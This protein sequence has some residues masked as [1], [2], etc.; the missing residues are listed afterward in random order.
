MTLCKGLTEKRE[1]CGK[2]L[3]AKSP[4][5]YC[6]KHRY[7]LDMTD[8]E[9]KNI[10]DGD[11]KY[12]ACSKCKKWFE[13]NNKR[14]VKCTESDTNQNEKRK[15]T[16]GEYCEALIS[17][18]KTKQC[19]SHQISNSK[20][21][22]KHEYLKDFTDDML[23]SSKI[24]T[25]PTCHRTFCDSPE[26]GTCQK[27]RKTG[28]QNRLYEKNQNVENKCKS[29]TCNNKANDKFG[30]GEYCGKCHESNLV[31]KLKDDIIRG[32]KKICRRWHHSKECLE[33]ID[34]GDK[35]DIC[36]ECRKSDN[37]AETKRRDNI[38]AEAKELDKNNEV[39]LE[40]IQNE[41]NETYQSIKH[42]KFTDRLSAMLDGNKYE[43]SINVS[44]DD[45]LLKSL[46]TYGLMTKLKKKCIN[47]NCRDE[48]L[49][50]DFV[51]ESFKVTDQCRTCR[52][53]YNEKNKDKKRVVV[54]KSDEAARRSKEYWKSNPELS[55]LKHKLHK[56]TK[57]LEMGEEEYNKKMA[58]QA[59]EYRDNNEE[60]MKLYYEAQKSNKK[61]GLRLYK[62][63]AQERNL[64]WDLT[65]QQVF[66]Y[67]DSVCGYCGEHDSKG[68]CG[69]D[70]IDDTKGYTTDNTCACCCMCNYMKGQLSYDDFINTARNV[71]NNMLGYGGEKYKIQ[72]I[73]KKNWGT[74]YL[75]CKRS[76]KNRKKEFNLTKEQHTM[77]IY[78]N[79]YMC[80]KN[81][82]GYFHHGIDRVNN[83]KGYVFDNCLSCCSV[84]NY[85]KK[86]YALH[87]V[88]KKLY[89][90][91]Y[92][93]DKKKFMDNLNNEMK[94]KTDVHVNKLFEENEILNNLMNDHHQRDNEN[95]NLSDSD[96][97]GIL[98]SDNN[99][100]AIKEVEDRPKKLKKNK[101]NKKVNADISTKEMD[102]DNSDSDFE[103]TP[104]NQ[105][106]ELLCED[107]NDSDGDGEDI[108][109]KIKCMEILKFTSAVSNQAKNFSV[110][111][112]DMDR[113]MGKLSEMKRYMQKPSV[114]KK[115]DTDKP[116][117]KETG[118]QK[119]GDEGKKQYDAARK[120]RQRA[121][122]SGNTKKIKE[123]EDR[124]ETLNKMSISGTE[125]VKKLKKSQPKLTEEEKIERKQRQKQERKDEQQKKIHQQ[126]AEATDKFMKKKHGDN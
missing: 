31:D 107:N 48:K 115:S 51:N 72:E 124:I 12:N 104:R 19:S 75:G 3:G 73:T 102:R 41:L 84:C 122:N 103:T 27:C 26:Y 111:I 1:I 88:V 108:D 70:R 61:C 25:I 28:E 57:K 101:E 92:I 95:S 68:R 125:V 47:K 5:R 7:M 85:L 121:I 39:A 97:Y 69:I 15:Q 94:K 10:A 120:M 38:K 67:F 81:V 116:I 58:Q 90:M 89:K 113:L 52:N 49:V 22:K 98:E 100:R 43:G 117:K 30:N 123:A 46:N 16:A 82:N 44:L 4:D 21:C 126:L 56:Q 35:H 11:T 74:T 23:A 53:K 65:E 2:K 93:L 112:S 29:N 105:S 110:N 114:D 13:G 106:R 17:I 63:R 118:I 40:D 87:N 76:A 55:S 119:Y 8:E 34:L 33:G 24:C 20:Y 86:E 42:K 50:V 37:V 99:V 9:I 62:Y 96:Y 60:R 45:I 18:D 83:D 80:G 54:K 36:V 59:Q 79:C 109:Y 77:L 64:E 91:I 66:N 78:Q 71:L 14:C 32:G 6:I